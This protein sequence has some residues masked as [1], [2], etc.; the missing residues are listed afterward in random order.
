MGEISVYYE[1]HDDQLV[2]ISMIVRGIVDLRY[3]YYW[4]INAPFKRF[5]T[6][7]FD[8][9]VLTVSVQLEELLINPELQH[10]VGLYLPAIRR[11]I[12]EHIDDMDISQYLIRFCDLEDVLQMDCNRFIWK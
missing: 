3:P 1:H 2:P 11:R 6:E 7:D 9:S 10:H 12:P 8:D 4:H 5:L